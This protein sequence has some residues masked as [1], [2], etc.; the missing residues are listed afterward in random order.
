VYSC[1]LIKND[2]DLR[3]KAYDDVPACTDKHWRDRYNEDTDLCIRALKKGWCTVLF[4]T[5]NSDKVTTMVMKGG[6]TDVL[7]AGDGRAKMAESLARQHPDVA[8]VGDRW[9]RKQHVVDYPKC[10]ELGKKNFGEDACSLKFKPGGRAKKGTVNNF[11]MI[12][13]PRKKT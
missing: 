13:V 6:N 1:T 10:V 11:G 3:M 5:F 12:R 4:V 2:L 7:Y 9:N 8:K